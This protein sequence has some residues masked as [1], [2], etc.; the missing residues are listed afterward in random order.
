MQ[1]EVQP[2][3]RVPTEEIMSDGGKG[4]TQRPTDQEKFNANWLRIFKKEAP[5]SVDASNPYKVATAIGVESLRRQID[6]DVM[7]ELQQKEEGK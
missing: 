2:G 3:A 6:A 4:S 7:R 5:A 1:S